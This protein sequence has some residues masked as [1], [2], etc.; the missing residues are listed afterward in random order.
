MKLNEARDLALSLMEKHGVSNWDF[1]FDKA[2]RRF[3]CC[4]YTD[5][6][7]TLSSYLT[8]LNDESHVRDTILH[9]IAHALVGPRNNHNHVWKR[10]AVEIG[11]TGDRCYSSAEVATPKA[12]YEATCE[13]CNK[14]YKM[15]RLPK[16]QHSCGRCS[17]GRFN[18]EFII[19][20]KR[21]E[22]V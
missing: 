3:G 20:W 14:T 8:E 7:I 17:G 5:M 12:P 10:K 15:Y 4:N 2:R 13:K 6:E 9:E 21:N 19:K 22:N 16:N 18:P 11:C 1:R